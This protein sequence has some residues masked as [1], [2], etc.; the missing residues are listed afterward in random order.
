MGDTERS[1]E[2]AANQPQGSLFWVIPDGYIPPESRGELL[3]HESICVL[4]CGNCAA[5]LSIDIY[6]EDR[7]PL[8]GMI[9]VVEGRRTRHIRTAS[10]E[11]SGERIPTGIPYAITVTSDVPIIVQYSRLDTTQ[12][13]LALM[14]VMAYPV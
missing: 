10:L 2:K 13:E 8:E 3:S 14:S 12:P 4:N 1:Q 9:E 11:K 6:F 7:E 5:K